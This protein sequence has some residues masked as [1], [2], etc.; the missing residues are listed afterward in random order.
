M[1]EKVLEEAK[2][3][4]K[5]EF[6]NRISDIVFFRPLDKN[7]L[8]SIVDLEIA[9][10]ATAARRPEDHAR[11]HA[12]V[13]GAPD[14]E[15]LRREVRRRP[16]RRAVEHYLEDPLAEAILRG[17]IKEGESVLV[18]RDGEVL[19]FKQKTPPAT[20]TGVAP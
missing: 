7:D 10:F 8:I 18:V 9:K 15:G 3:V 11:V 19:N 16:L 20:T 4:F 6:L 12:R 1:R 2:R 14:R 17:E 5:P 13:Q